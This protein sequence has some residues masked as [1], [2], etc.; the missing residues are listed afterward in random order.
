MRRRDVVVSSGSWPEESRFD[1][2]LRAYQYP[3]SGLFKYIIANIMH[4][5]DHRE[6]YNQL[7]TIGLK[8]STR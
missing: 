4:N 3:C 2:C 8:S 5:I 6:T 7:I 1:S